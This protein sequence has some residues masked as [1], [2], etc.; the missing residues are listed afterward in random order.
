MIRLDH[1]EAFLL[2]RCRVD[3][4]S[5]LPRSIVHVNFDSLSVMK[6]LIPLSTSDNF[7]RVITWNVV[8]NNT[9]FFLQIFRYLV[10]FL[11]FIS[12]LILV[13]QFY[14]KVF[15]VIYVLLVVCGLSQMLSMISASVWLNCRE[16]HCGNQKCLGRTSALVFE[17]K[18][19]TTVSR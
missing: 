12:V 4:G 11:L 10:P 8:I 16:G 2:V 18:V 3:T 5:H 19:I 13:Y 15:L 7:A 9:K 17:W 14:M 6:S 1:D